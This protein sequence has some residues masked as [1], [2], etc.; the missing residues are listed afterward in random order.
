M[1]IASHIIVAGYV[2]EM[3]GNPFLAFLVGIII[4]FLLDSIPHYDTTDNG[5]I[6]K[7]QLALTVTD[8][9]VGIILIVFLLKADLGLKSPF[10]WG[11]FGGIFP[12]ILDN[13][14]FWQKAFRNTVFGKKFHKFHEDIQSVRLAP[15]PGLLV[16][17]IVIVIFLYLYLHR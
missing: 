12:D 10:F 9:F 15:V 6:T 11:A 1:L 5:K 4:H 7:R 13:V 17:A 3:I 8:G 2:G 14:P 16:Q